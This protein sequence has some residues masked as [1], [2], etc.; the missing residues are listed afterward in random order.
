MPRTAKNATS[1]GK[2]PTGGK[3]CKA[4]T[5]SGQ[6]CKRKP[7]PGLT[8][9]ASHG[10]STA[11]SVRVSKKAKVSQQVQGLWGISSDT[12]DVD[13][14]SELRQLIRNKLTDVRALRLKLGQDPDGHIGVII[15]SRDTTKYDI[16]GTVQSKYGTTRKIVRKAGTSPWVQE[17]HKAEGE[18]LVML[19]LWQE[20]TGSTDADSAKRL[21]MQTAREAARLV[22]AYPG[23][24]VDQ[25]ALEVSK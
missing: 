14:T 8:V 6:P 20:L 15:D 13:V 10:G 1:K 2:T 16:D 4:L 9:C 24:T 19:R 17:L 12:S 3:R 22:K 25:V 11:A 18:L 23:I 21:K 7:V 5:T